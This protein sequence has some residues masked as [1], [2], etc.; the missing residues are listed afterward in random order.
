[1]AIFWS[2]FSWPFLFFNTILREKLFY[3]SGHNKVYEHIYCVM[4]YIKAYL[5]IRLNILTSFVRLLTWSVTEFGWKRSFFCIQ[6]VRRKKIRIFQF[7]F[8]K[9]YRISNSLFIYFSILFENF[10]MRSYTNR[11]YLPKDVRTSEYLKVYEIPIRI[12]ATNLVRSANVYCS[13]T[14]SQR[15]NSCNIARV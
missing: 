10:D 4:Y 5:V 12:R 6:S 2:V 3:H 8:L 1:M 13:L 9:L 14:K 15:Y 7:N 11:I